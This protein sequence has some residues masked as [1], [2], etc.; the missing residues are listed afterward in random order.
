MTS[1]TTK[2]QSSALFLL[3]PEL[4]LDICGHLPTPEHSKFTRT[5]RYL[6]KIQEYLF[7]RCSPPNNGTT[8]Y[9]QAMVY[10]CTK[11]SN[12]VIRRS[13]LY[14]CPPTIDHVI[15][16]MTALSLASSWG[17]PEAVGYVLQHHPDVNR[18]G[19]HGL[20]A[21]NHA[22]DR[23][24]IRHY[25]TCTK[26]AM[27]LHIETA[28]KLLNAGANP[29][30]RVPDGLSGYQGLAN[31]VTV[32]MDAVHLNRL[33]LEPFAQLVRELVCKGG[34]PDGRGRYGLSPLQVAVMYHEQCPDFLKTLLKNG[35]DPNYG[36]EFGPPRSGART[37]L[38]T[39]IARRDA[40]AMRYLILHGA[41][42]GP[43][44]EGAMNPLWWAVKQGA[45]EP[46]QILLDH[47]ADPNIVEFA[48]NPDNGSYLPTVL[49]VAVH[50]QTHFAPTNKPIFENL[51]EH[52]AD[53][54]LQCLEGKTPLWSALA[55]D[56]AA[57][58]VEMLLRY[59]A[60]PNGQ[61]VWGGWTPLVG[62]IE[63]RPRPNPVPCTRL[64][65]A[66]EQRLEIVEKLMKAGADVNLCVKRNGVTLSPLQVALT[67]AYPDGRQASWKELYALPSHFAA[68]SDYTTLK[69]F[70]N[71]KKAELGGAPDEAVVLQDVPRHVWADVLTPT[72]LRARARVDQGQLDRIGEI[73][74]L[75]GWHP[76][77]LQ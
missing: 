29:N 37:A 45:E 15:D 50:D 28:L 24:G 25:T 38:A 39:A 31:A 65:T 56:H 4:L 14:G 42:L 1:L 53:P 57:P 34:R 66:S 40:E 74:R 18:E 10:G 19:P 76:D 60:D 62:A 64:P 73:L 5:C 13:L 61:A 9:Y 59:G 51:L 44:S 27:L 7:K 2:G 67:T 71:K 69:T 23:I 36:A 26:A 41:N 33:T 77:Q 16:R 22:L 35:A 63:V 11:P 68:A 8:D 58:I 72:L 75:R 55:T 49:S 6:A 46:V 20:T 21:L 32:V 70:F 43:A 47:G 30:C 54:N 17:D 52:G 3:P 12:P 48:R